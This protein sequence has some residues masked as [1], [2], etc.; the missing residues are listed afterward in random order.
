MSSPLGLLGLAAR[1]G[2][3]A[4]GYDP[5]VR[6][7]AEGRARLLL[8]AADVSPGTRRRLPAGTVPT[9]VIPHPGEAVGRA[10]G[11]P[12]PVRVLA[13][14]DEGLAEALLTAI[15]NGPP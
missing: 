3:L 4:A 6:A 10:V 15:D 2:R 8:L 7:L 9:R 5:V 13:V 12:G 11:R 1:A 14:L